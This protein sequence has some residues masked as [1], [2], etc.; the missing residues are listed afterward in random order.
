MAH[1]TAIGIRRPNRSEAAPAEIET[2]AFVTLKAMTMRR[3]S[4]TAMPR[5]C[6]R[7]ARNAS[8]ELPRVKRALAPTKIQNAAGKRCQ[9]V[10]GTT[11]V[12]VGPVAVDAAARARGTSR[13]A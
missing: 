4:R 3:R 9:P 10:G 2:R 1:A 13:T 11:P 6:D 5:F 12:A 8:L 7:R